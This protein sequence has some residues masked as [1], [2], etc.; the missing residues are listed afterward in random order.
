[1]K[2]R[3]ALGSFP[4]DALMFSE[5]YSTLS[6][7]DTPGALSLFAGSRRWERAMISKGCPWV[8]CIDTLHHPELDLTETNLRATLDE[9]IDA[10]AFK[11]VGGGP[12]LLVA[13]RCSDT[14]DPQ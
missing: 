7:P 4:D 10:G 11:A 2:A 6:H 14:A 1:M 9:L 13:V 3:A 8:L 12:P 5:G